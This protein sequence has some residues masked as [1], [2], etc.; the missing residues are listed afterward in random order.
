ME[1]TNIFTEPGKRCECRF[2]EAGRELKKII[3][4]LPDTKEL[5]HGLLT[6]LMEISTDETYWRELYKGEGS[7]RTEE[8]ANA[9][10]ELRIT[11]IRAKK[12]GTGRD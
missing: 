7:W 4:K 1:P 5:L 9:A 12:Q 11:N 6:E 10:H 8:E 2:C 3:D